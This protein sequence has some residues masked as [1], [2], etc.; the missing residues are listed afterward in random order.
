MALFDNFLQPASLTATPVSRHAHLLI[1]WCLLALALTTW[2][3]HAHAQVIPDN[4]PDE[5]ATAD[6]INHDFSVSFCELCEIG[7]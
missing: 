6:I 3:A 4:C 7:T 1:A 5:L 2:S